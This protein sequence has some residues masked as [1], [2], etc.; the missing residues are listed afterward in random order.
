VAFPSL[1]ICTNAARSGAHVVETA[2]HRP[3]FHG[4]EVSTALQAWTFGIVLLINI[5]GG[6]KSGSIGDPATARA[7]VDKLKAFFAKL[8]QRWFLGGR[9]GDVLREL[10]SQGGMPPPDPAN[11]VPPSHKRP[12][13]ATAPSSATASAPAPPAQSFGLSAAPAPAANSGAAWQRKPAGGG[14]SIS[15]RAS[16]DF[17]HAQALFH[18]TGQHSP[19]THASPA[20][21]IQESTASSSGFADPAIDADIVSHKH[22]PTLPRSNSDAS[23]GFFGQPFSQS[24]RQQQQQPDSAAAVIDP[25][26]FAAFL[27]AQASMAG[28]GGPTAAPAFSSGF[29][30][31]GAGFG[32]PPASAADP[33]PQT[34]SGFPDWMNASSAG[35]SWPQPPASSAASA[36]ASGEATM[37][38]LFANGTFPIFSPPGE[39]GPSLYGNGTPGLNGAPPGLFP[40]GSGPSSAVPGLWDNAPAA[41]EC[42]SSCP[43]ILWT[44]CMLTCAFCP[45]EWTTGA[46]TSRSLAPRTPTAAECDA[47]RRLHS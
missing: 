9:I 7:D 43:V 13:G 34:A 1:A 18:Q 30:P 38:L 45:S 29:P 39:N 31:G 14:H 20:P 16:A 5:W 28:A 46:R 35:A 42:V 47:R 44:S 12:R 37:D 17:S 24:E 36:A 41:F 21:S 6:K 25:V 4:Y 23:L 27:Q 8:E 2:R 15:K 10:A 11:V 3:R 40:S 22:L 33:S 26:H 19:T 32:L